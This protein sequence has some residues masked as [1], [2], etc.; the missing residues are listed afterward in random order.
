MNAKDTKPLDAVRELYEKNLQQHGTTSKAVGWRDNNSHE[1]R[2]SMLSYVIEAGAPVTINDL[3]CGYGAFLGFLEQRKMPVRGFYGYD[4]SPGMLEEARRRYPDGKWIEGSVLESVAD[5]SFACGIFNVRLAASEEAWKQY[6]ERTL[7]NLNDRSTRG[8]AFN[9][10]TTYVDFRAP[11]L[12][13]ADPAYYFDLCKQRYSRRV[14]LLHDSPLY[15][16]TMIVR[17]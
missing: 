10:L 17:K 15:E 7:D 4:I 8:F 1:I 11:D 6:I 3:G 2:F 13:Y 16:W 12:F 14:A 5:Y 9:L